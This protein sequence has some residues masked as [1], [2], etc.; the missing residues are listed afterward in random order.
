MCW[1]SAYFGEEL[2]LTCD[3][4]KF[5]AGRNFQRTFLA[6]KFVLRSLELTFI[7]FVRTQNF[8]ETIVK[9]WAERKA[10]Q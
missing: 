7:I 6:S 3:F 1:I 4:I 10:W 9:V 2:F 8:R 5:D